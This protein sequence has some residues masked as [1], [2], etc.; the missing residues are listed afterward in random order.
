MANVNAPAG[1]SPVQYKNGAPWTGGGRV[2]YIAAADVNAYAIGDPV[3]LSGSGD[4]N[5]V[6]GVTLATAGTASPV[7]GPILG[8]GG[9]VMGG[10]FTDPANINTTVIPAAKTKGYYVLVC[11]DPNVIF[12]MQEGGAGAAL[13]AS[14]IGQNVNLLA[15]TNSGYFSGWTFNNATTG[16]GATLQLQLMGLALKAGNGFGQYAKWLVRINNHQYA[17]G[18]AG[19]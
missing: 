13:S 19:V 5:G 18:V 7:L 2:Y 9:I 16:T 4:G 17:A 12:E 15:G 11:D 14:N 6:P 8:S 10:A 1:L 3:T